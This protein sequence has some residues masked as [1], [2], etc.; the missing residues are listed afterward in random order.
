[1]NWLKHDLHNAN[2]QRDKTPWIV[3]IGHRPIY[4]SEMLYSNHSIAIQQAKILQDAF[5]DILH[6]Y[7][8]DIFLVG[9]VH[10]YERTYPVYRNKVVQH[11]T[12]HIVAGGA[13][14]LEGLTPDV[15]FPERGVWSAHL[16]NSD[17]GYGV[18]STTLDDKDAELRWRYYR[19]TDDGL[20][21]E[22]VLKKKY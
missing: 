15:N 20:E 10:S 9:H 17:E 16:C 11:S 21:D 14:N 6:E 3:V 7:Q 4:S 1:L 2:K 12:I 8:V 22:L 13:G 5:E 19:S 18:L